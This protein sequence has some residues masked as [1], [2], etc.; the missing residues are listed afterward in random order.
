MYE[1]VL[2][3]ATPAFIALMLI[4]CVVARLRR[5]SEYR[6]AD[7]VTSVSLGA[8]STYVGVFARLVSFGVYVLVYRAAR[9]ATLNVDAWWVWVGALIAY[10]F[11]YYWYHRLGHEV[12]VLWAA[13]VVHHQSEDYNL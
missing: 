2:L 9:L 8:L 3:W 11:L 13:H 4:E 6:L 10:D 1:K 12:N 5:V 7:A